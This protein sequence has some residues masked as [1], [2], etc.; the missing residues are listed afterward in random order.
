[1]LVGS[2]FGAAATSASAKH[3]SH[4]IS[5]GRNAMVTT[6][7]TVASARKARGRRGNAWRVYGPT[8]TTAASVA[9]LCAD[10]MRHVLQDHELWTTN[11]AM[12]RPGCEHGDIRCLSVVGWVFLTCTSLGFACLIVG[13]L[14]NA[15]A[16][17]QLGR[18]FR[19][20]LA[21]DD[22]DFEA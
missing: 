2:F 13:A 16:L 12:Y 14:W 11:S 7:A 22:A 5:L 15:D 1:M 17:G 4:A 21:G 9:L 19:R 20:R 10:P 8:A 3:E 18:E 6:L